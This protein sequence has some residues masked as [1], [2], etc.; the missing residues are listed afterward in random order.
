MKSSV[1]A[2]Q[3]CLDSGAS[4]WR[5]S[6]TALSQPEQPFIQAEPDRLQLRWA[7]PR[8]AP[9]AAPGPQPRQLVGYAAAG[10][11][12]QTSFIYEKPV[13]RASNSLKVWMWWER[14]EGGA[15]ES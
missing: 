9:A 4:W 13:L 1:G 3:V 5:D 12:R 8:T 10:P 6:H 11:G 15:A 14:C 2:V 7:S